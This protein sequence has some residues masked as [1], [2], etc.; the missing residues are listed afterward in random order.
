MGAEI[1]DWDNLPFALAQSLERKGYCYAFIGADDWWMYPLIPPGSF[2]Q[3]DQSKQK[4]Q[5]DGWSTDYERPIYFVEHQEGYTCG[6]C[7]VDKGWLLLL[8]H[9]SSRFAPK[10]L[11]QERADIVGQVRG[12][13]MRQGL[14]RRIHS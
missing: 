11:R 14:R 5:R 8:P 12:I 9:P 3:I 13:A 1:S 10:V 6:W 4:I 2:V 7:Q